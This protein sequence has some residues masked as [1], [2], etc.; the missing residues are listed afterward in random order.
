M[1]LWRSVN[2]SCFCHGGLWNLQ[3]DC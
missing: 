1:T 3:R 2:R